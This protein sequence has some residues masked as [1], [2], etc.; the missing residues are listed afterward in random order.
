M[1]VQWIK[2]TW[3]ITYRK[4]AV[5]HWKHFLRVYY[6]CWKWFILFHI[7]IKR[8]RDLLYIDSTRDVYEI[9]TTF[10]NILIKHKLLIDFSVKFIAQLIG[11][12]FFS[13]LP[14]W[15]RPWVWTPDTGA[16]MNFII[17]HSTYLPLYYDNYTF[18]LCDHFA[19]AP[20]PD[21]WP[22]SHEFRNLGGKLHLRNNCHRW[23]VT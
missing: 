8:E 5:F 9:K 13:I 16:F 6:I 12:Y 23:P 17:I 10:Y 20:G 4:S 3:L 2:F 18:S 7:L 1:N 11:V 15:P 22:R 19:S 14:Y 21:L